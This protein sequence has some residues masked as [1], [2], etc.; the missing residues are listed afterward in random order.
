MTTLALGMT[1][2]GEREAGRAWVWAGRVAT[3]LP[4][5]F[6]AMDTAMHLLRPPMAVEGTVEL[7]FSASILIPL[8]IIQAISLLMYLVPPT[9]VLGAIVW[10]GY[11]GGAVATHVRLGN[12]MFT[13]ILS[14]VYVAIFLWGALWLTDARVRAILPLGRASR[15]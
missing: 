9:R 15:G 6:L 7:G 2:V 8:G 11:L 14:P 3:A 13:H 10:T 12:P 4:V 1:G 5:L